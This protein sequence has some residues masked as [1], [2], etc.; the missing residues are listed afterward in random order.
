MII[1]R[2]CLLLA[3]SFL[4]KTE[5]ACGAG[6]L[7]PKDL[8]LVT[9]KSIRVLIYDTN[10]S[11]K[12]EESAYAALFDRKSREVG[13]TTTVFGAGSQFKGFGS[14]YVAVAPLLQKMDPET[15][16][17]ISDGRDVVLNVP[18]MEQAPEALHI[19]EC[20]SLLDS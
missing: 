8:A 16:V 14:K 2:L 9:D 10:D 6:V 11:L 17:V 13:I 3:A 5:Q 15:L 18:N 20:I 7:E 19:R 1:D 4:A 12:N